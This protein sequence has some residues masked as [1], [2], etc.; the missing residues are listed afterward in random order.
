MALLLSLS[1]SL[2]LSLC[3]SLSL[4]SPWSTFQGS[5]RRWPFEVT[6][7]VEFE[8]PVFDRIPSLVAALGELRGSAA[9]SSGACICFMMEERWY[10]REGMGTV[11]VSSRSKDQRKPTHETSI[12]SLSKHID[13]EELIQQAAD[14]P[15]V[16]LVQ[17][18]GGKSSRKHHSGAHAGR[19]DTEQIP[20]YTIPA[21]GIS[22]DAAYQIIT[23]ELSLDGKPTLNLASFVHTWMP[24]KGTKLMS[25]NM[26]I[27][28]CDQD[29]Y[30]A[31]M[32]MHARCVSMLADLWKA[33]KEFDEHGK[34]K[35]AMGV[36][37]TGSSEAI[38]LGCLAAKKRWQNRMKAQGKSFK[39]PG[40][41]MVFGSN[42][43]VAIEKFARY[44]DVEE[45]LVP[46]SENSRYCLDINKAIEMV[47]ENTICVVVILG[48]TYTGHYEDVLGMSKLLDAYQEKT[49][50]DIPIHVDGASG[51]MV[52]PFAHPH[53]KWSFE[54]PRVLSIN[55]SGHKFG[56]VYPGLGWVLFRSTE[57]VPK[58]L[59]FELHY[60]GSVEYSF[61]L[62]FS[63]PAAPVLGQLFNFL[64]LG[65][66]GYKGVMRADLQNAR[67]LSRALELSGYYEVLSDIHRPVS[68]V[69]EVGAKLGALDEHD[70]EG[71]TPGLPVVSFKWSKAFVEKN[72]HLEQRWMQTLLR[73]KGWIVPNYNLSPDLESVDI[74]R[75]VVRENLSADMI[76]MLVADIMEITESLE[77]D[78]AAAHLAK[79]T[80][81]V[82]ENGNRAENEEEQKGGATTN[83]KKHHHHH[84][85]HDKHRANLEKGSGTKAKG[86]SKQC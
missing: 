49:G 20:K 7:I 63:R 29:E 26:N 41:N 33:P 79:I 81:K 5:W 52:A 8:V 35:P 36:A 25:E 69:S 51:A 2:S 77:S 84:N 6:S 24:E 72:P 82:T 65:F 50:I 39:E 61:G 27:N 23:D 85:S 17:R 73:A 45:R 71:Y 14:H 64:N 83:H 28:L 66:E 42:A 19:Y 32:S 38:M 46:I 9:G 74:L 11:V 18:A 47:D 68:K 31:T 80:S 34:R 48:S 30:P 3:L 4:V 75:V 57:M 40:P 86:Y 76:D 43:Q 67:L 60:L 44:F 70:P 58:E 55:T 37:T 16:G 12:M 1:L 13:A 21:K 78:S 56:M 15:Y 54:V 22:E 10:R 62:N 59:I 53:L